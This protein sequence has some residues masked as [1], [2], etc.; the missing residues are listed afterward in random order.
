MHTLVSDTS[1]AKQLPKE[2]QTFYPNKSTYNQPEPLKHDENEGAV[3]QKTIVELLIKH[4]ADLN[5]ISS[6]NETPLAMAMRLNNHYLVA[7][8]IK[9]GARFWMDVDSNGNNFFHYFGAYTAFIN[10]LQP[11]YDLDILVRERHK[12]IAQQM[13]T[14]VELNSTSHMLD[15][16]NTVSTTK[17]I[18]C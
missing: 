15:I 17:Y 11:H 18:F 1:F 3:Y 9:S 12:E 5:M 4:G 13:W 10:G 7:T 6:M 2:W 8:L 14:S 16:E